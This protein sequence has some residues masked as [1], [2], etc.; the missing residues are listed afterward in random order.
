MSAESY[1]RKTSNVIRENM[2]IN[3]VGIEITSDMPEDINL[4]KVLI[5]LKGSV[6]SA[7]FK[8]LNGIKV[9]DLEEFEER[10]ISAKYSSD[11]QILYVSAQRQ[12]SNAD[13]LDDL[14][15]E[16]GHHAEFLYDD[17][18][19]GDN[20][21]RD[22][23]HLKR[24][25]LRFEV[26]ADVDDYTQ[27]DFKDVAYDPEFDTFLYK[28]IG[29]EKIKMMTAGM[30]VRPYQ[31]MSLREYFAVGFEQYYLGNHK[32]LHRDCPVLYKRLEELD[33]EARKESR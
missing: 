16:I 22:E 25:E 13:M 11:D 27:F 20:I 31:A 17:F 19:Y 14:I 5:T 15:H 18:I 24:M 26:A 23:F 21:I 7:Y 30:F 1:I 10:N 4:S 8:K 3:Q 32:A 28:R 6:P 2:S 33:L 12:D 29:K 9:L